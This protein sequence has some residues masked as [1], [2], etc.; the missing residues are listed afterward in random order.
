MFLAERAIRLKDWNEAAL[1]LRLLCE[2]IPDRADSRHQNARK[3][4]LAVERHLKKK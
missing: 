4:L 3:K 2:K 1:Q